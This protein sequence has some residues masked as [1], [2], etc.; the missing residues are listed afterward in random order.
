MLL[1]DSESEPDPEEEL[2]GERNQQND[3][4]SFKSDNTNSSDNILERFKENAYT[5]LRDFGNDKLLFFL[6]VL[7]VFGAI[8][9]IYFVPGSNDDII[10]SD[11]STRLERFRTSFVE[12]RAHFPSQNSR[13]WQISRSVFLINRIG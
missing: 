4:N 7:P 2:D 9:L 3:S 8:A 1:I 5:W 6:I 12:I 10:N 11:N 13:L